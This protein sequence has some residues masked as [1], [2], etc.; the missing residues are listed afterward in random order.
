MSGIKVFRIKP[1]AQYVLRKCQVSLHLAV[2]NEVAATFCYL[3]S[4]FLFFPSPL[5]LSI[6][7]SLLHSILEVEPR[8]LL[9]LGRCPMSCTSSLRQPSEGLGTS[10]CCMVCCFQQP[11]GVGKAVPPGSHLPLERPTGQATL[12]Q[13]TLYPAHSSAH[14]FTGRRRLP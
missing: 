1:D 6:L 11:C 12:Y 4:H 5:P 14:S 7:H 13:A 10:V 8:A 2:S 3:K 9:I